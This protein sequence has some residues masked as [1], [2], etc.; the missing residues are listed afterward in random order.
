MREDADRARSHRA[1]AKQWNQSGR[2]SLGRGYDVENVI[3]VAE[4]ES[5]RVLQ[6]WDVGRGV[7]VWSHRRKSREE[8]GARDC[9]VYTTGVGRRDPRGHSRRINNDRL[10]PNIPVQG[11]SPW[12]STPHERCVTVDMMLALT[13]TVNDRSK[14]LCVIWLYVSRSL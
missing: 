3:F 8:R 6:A 7:W 4:E 10:L 1:S 5:R 12:F 13:L 11:P 14:L 9:G 2:G